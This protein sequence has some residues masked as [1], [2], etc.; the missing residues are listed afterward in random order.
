MKEIR[1]IDIVVVQGDRPR[2]E[3]YMDGERLEML[4]E[5]TFI[6]DV[7]RVSN[8]IDADLTASYDVPSDRV[9]FINGVL[10]INNPTFD[11]KTDSIDTD[12]FNSIVIGEGW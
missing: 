6:D 8:R 10:Y 3:A 12:K 7:Y 2:V 4:K 5:I 11:E 9:R 1:K